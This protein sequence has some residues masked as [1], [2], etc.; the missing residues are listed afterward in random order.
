MPARS[1]AVTSAETGPG[2]M[3]QISE[4]TSARRRPDF[5][6]RLGFVVTPSASP[7]SARARISETSAVSTKNFMAGGTLASGADARFAFVQG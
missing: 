7:A 1:T 5:A 6:M 2:V 3:V 4:I